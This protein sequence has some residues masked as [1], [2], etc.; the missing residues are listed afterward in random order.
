MV[1]QSA[2][3][4]RRDQPEIAPRLRIWGMKGTSVVFQALFLADASSH[5]RNAFNFGGSATPS[6]DT[7]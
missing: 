7:R 1:R 3:P 5:C 2:T 6:G 4:Q